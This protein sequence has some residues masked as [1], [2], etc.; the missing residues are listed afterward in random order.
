MV[1]WRSLMTKAG[2]SCSSATYRRIASWRCDTT[3]RSTSSLHKV[4]RRESLGK[5]TLQLQMS[6]R[7]KE[8][9]L[10]KSIEISTSLLAA[11]SSGF[12]SPKPTSKRTRRSLQLS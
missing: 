3:K 6:A 5:C 11:Q 2:I 8:W 10:T 7:W 9:H 4:Q 1:Q 12:R